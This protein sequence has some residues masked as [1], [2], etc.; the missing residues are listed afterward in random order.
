MRREPPSSIAPVNDDSIQWIYTVDLDREVF[1][2]NN[3]AHFKLDQVPHI[4][5]IRSLANGGLGDT[6][7]LPGAVPMEAV[8]SL[9]VEHIFQS[10]ELSNTLSDPTVS[11]VGSIYRYCIC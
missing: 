10:S 2:V 11:E 6:I 8:T 5:W 9:M 1:T 7:S 3:R 4:D